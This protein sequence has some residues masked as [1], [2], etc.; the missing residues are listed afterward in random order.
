MGEKKVIKF[1]FTIEGMIKWETYPNIKGVKVFVGGLGWVTP[2]SYSVKVDSTPMFDA[3]GVKL[4]SFGKGEVRET[5]KKV[6]P[7]IIG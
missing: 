1:P 2:N 3:Q 6:T 7:K 4:G 5:P